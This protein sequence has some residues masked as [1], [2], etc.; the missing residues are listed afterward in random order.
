MLFPIILSGGSGMRLWPVSRRLMPK[1]LQRLVS[2]HS[3]L[4]ETVLRLPT[5]DMCAAPIVV[6]NHEHRFLVAEQLQELDV[7]PQSLILEP[8][9]RN[10][11]PAV[12]VAALQSLAQGED[13]LLLVLAADH[14]IRDMA[15]FHAA[16]ERALPVA[17]QGHL[18]T[19]GIVPHR[20]ET[21]YGYIQ[22]GDLLD[23]AQDVYKVAAFSEKPNATTAKHYVET[24][25]YYWNSGMFLMRAQ[26]YLDELERF[27]PDVLKAC[28]VALENSHR[29]QD[30]CRL[31]ERAFAQSPSISID[32]A[33]MEKTT[34]AALLPIDIGW[35]DIG[36]WTTLW[37]AQAQDADGNVFRGDVYTLEAKSCY[38]S[39][40]KRVVA[41]VGVE[42]LVIV[43]TSDAIL[44]AHKDKSQD[45]KKIVERLQ[46]DG[47]NET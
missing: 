40:Q 13:A 10:T 17:R 7:M 45:V 20:A 12:A 31:E 35:S 32:N 42:N 44:V 34:Q 41:A 19:F 27:C 14:L 18:V 37:E 30:F 47:R 24:G 39:A 23:E 28:R 15:G 29:D 9:G 8:V 36:S 2:K 43:E 26:Q 3:M 22:R 33:V 11:A 21:G 6:C 5:L 38:I 46:S 1:Q 25:E 16:I 4:Q